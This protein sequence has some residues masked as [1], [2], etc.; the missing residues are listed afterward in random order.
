MFEDR[1]PSTFPQFSSAWWIPIL[2]AVGW[3]PLFADDLIYGNV[4]NSGMNPGM[5]F[6]MAWGMGVALPCT[7]SAVVSIVVQAFKLL[8]YVLSQPKD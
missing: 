7:L 6:A 4:S 5:G 3:G 1:E 2:L 8:L